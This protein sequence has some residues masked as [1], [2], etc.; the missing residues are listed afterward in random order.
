[1]TTRDAAG[2]GTEDPAI[3]TYRAPEIHEPL[4]PAAPPPGEAARPASS[5]KGHEASVRVIREDGLVRRI[6]IDCACGRAIHLECRYNEPPHGA[7]EETETE[8]CDE[9]SPSS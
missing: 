2:R 5:P 6:E 3:R 8:P 1:M 4:R 7:A 9:S